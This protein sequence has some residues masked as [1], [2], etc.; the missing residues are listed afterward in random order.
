MKPG[1]RVVLGLW[2]SDSGLFVPI[3]GLA[4]ELVMDSMAA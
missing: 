3:T 2:L 4:I 1:D